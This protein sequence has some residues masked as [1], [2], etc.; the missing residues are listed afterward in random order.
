MFSPEKILWRHVRQFARKRMGYQMPCN[1][2]DFFWRNLVIFSDARSIAFML[3]LAEFLARII[4][5]FRIGGRFVCEKRSIFLSR[6]LTQSRV[7]KMRE[8]KAFAVQKNGRR[9]SRS[10]WF[11]S[12]AA[13]TDECKCQG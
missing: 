4:L 11:W 2:D 10:Q 5:W 13:P 8:R 1:R 7:V 12:V 9:V 3:P 6:V